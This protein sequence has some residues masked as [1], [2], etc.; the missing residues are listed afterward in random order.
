[1]DQ[2]FVDEHGLPRFVQCALL[3]VDVLGVSEMSRGDDADG[4]LRR[5]DDAVRGAYRDFLAE[6]SPWPAAYFSDTFVLASPVGEGADAAG[7]AVAEIVDQAAWLQ[8]DL[9]ER[10]FFVRGAIT[11]GPFHLRE[12][13]VFG[14]ALVEAHDLEQRTALHPRIVLGTDA[15][16]SQRVAMEASEGEATSRPLLRDS[17]GRVFVD[18]MRVLL[19]DPKDP[20][21]ILEAFREAVMHPLRE[22][23]ASRVVWEKYRWVAEYHNQR[24]ASQPSGIAALTVPEDLMTRRFSGVLNNRR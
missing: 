21:P 23:R 12:G 17:D 6:D 13:F 24:L 4:Q 20:I 15:E 9:L 19:D 14:P 8:L 7:A 16:K 22:H 5:L 3:F 2:V 11:L 18:Y 10:G 1:M